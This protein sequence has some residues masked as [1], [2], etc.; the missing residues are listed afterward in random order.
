MMAL[1]LST[2]KNNV[3]SGNNL[4]TLFNKSQFNQVKKKRKRKHIPFGCTACGFAAFSQTAYINHVRLMH[5]GK[6]KSPVALQL[7]KQSLSFDESSCKKS[8]TL[9]DN[10]NL[11]PAVTTGS[12][13]LSIKKGLLLE[14]DALQNLND[15]TETQCSALDTGKFLMSF[16]CLMDFRFMYSI[17]TC[18]KI[19]G[20]IWPF[21]FHKF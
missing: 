14:D 8:K 1:S 17:W 21:L 12:S 5:I 19:Y 6:L 9:V 15:N 16:L 2:G 3:Q 20:R 7:M 11:G 13:V 10:S 4:S 18:S